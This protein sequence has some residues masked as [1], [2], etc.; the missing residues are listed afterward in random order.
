MLVSRNLGNIKELLKY[1]LQTNSYT[2][3]FIFF[4]NF[5]TLPEFEGAGM[6][7]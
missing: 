2:Y 6:H 7:Q 3:I 5:N 4:I 1:V